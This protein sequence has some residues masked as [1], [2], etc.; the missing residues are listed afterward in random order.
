MGTYLFSVSDLA[1]FFTDP[2]PGFFF[3]IRIPNPGNKK[4]IF[5]SKN[6]ILGE[7]F[8]SNQT[9]SSLLVPMRYCKIK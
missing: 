8:V 6:K 2:D 1:S 3:P 5:Q 4:Q 9:P 7:S